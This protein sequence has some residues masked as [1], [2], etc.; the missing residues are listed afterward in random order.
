MHTLCR[1]L[2]NHLCIII[3]YYPFCI[4]SNVRKYA[5]ELIIIIGQKPG[6]LRLVDGQGRSVSRLT[7]GLPINAGFLQA[8]YNDEWG[9]V[10]DSTDNFKQKEA[11]VAC[12]QLGYSK[13][14]NYGTNDGGV[15]FLHV[16]V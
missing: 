15:E 2:V 12:K 5:I 16:Y 8:F 1:S 7:G 4:E 10:C 9:R 6:S 14:I 3:H 13:A 11:D